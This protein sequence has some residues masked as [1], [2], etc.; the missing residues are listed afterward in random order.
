MEPKAIFIWLF[1][2]PGIGAELP[3]MESRLELTQ[4]PQ[5]TQHEAH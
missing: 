5:H 4:H 3:V 1:P 2:L